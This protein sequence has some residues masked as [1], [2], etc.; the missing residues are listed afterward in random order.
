MHSQYL[1]NLHIINYVN[2]RHS[3]SLLFKLTSS[4]G[5]FPENKTLPEVDK[6]LPNIYG[7]RMFVTA[8]TKACHFSLT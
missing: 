3:L 5:V 2:P 8:L 1:D 7:N 4:S 6:K